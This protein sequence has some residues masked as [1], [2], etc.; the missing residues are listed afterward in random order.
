[1]KFTRPAE[2]DIDFLQWLKTQSKFH[3]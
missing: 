2:S 3:E 1:V